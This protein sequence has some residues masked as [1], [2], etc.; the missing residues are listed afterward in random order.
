MIDNWFSKGI[1]YLCMLGLLLQFLLFLHYV[2]E[3]N[4]RF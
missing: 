4:L 1:S 3:T 2:Q